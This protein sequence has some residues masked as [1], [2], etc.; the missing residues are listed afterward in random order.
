MHRGQ[1]M[2]GRGT[3]SARHC[4]LQRK[5]KPFIRPGASFIVIIRLSQPLHSMTDPVRSGKLW[6]R[7]REPLHLILEPVHLIMQIIYYQETERKAR[8]YQHY[9]GKDKEV[10]G[11]VS[12]FLSFSL[13]LS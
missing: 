10:P 8:E 12:N 2:N 7:A 4:A 9:S 13:M 6:E 3:D 1:L 11:V 5:R